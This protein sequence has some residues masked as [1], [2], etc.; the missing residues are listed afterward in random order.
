MEYKEVN[1]ELVIE[2]LNNSRSIG[3][4]CGNNLF[5]SILVKYASDINN[6]NDIKK[7]EDLIAQ[8]YGPKG[9]T[10]QMIL[11]KYI[12]EALIYYINKFNIYVLSIQDKQ[13]P[14]LYY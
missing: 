8:S 3:I 11:Y 4:N 14:I 13:E 9:P 12:K 1:R 10:I 5:Y 2:A 6:F 7:I